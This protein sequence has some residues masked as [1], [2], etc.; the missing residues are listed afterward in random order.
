LVVEKTGDL[1]QWSDEVN[2][3][4]HETWW[5]ARRRSFSTATALPAQ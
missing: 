5:K 3:Y 1:I 2:D 4:L